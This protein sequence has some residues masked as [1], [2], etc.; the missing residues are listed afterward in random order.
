ML[1]KCHWIA[2]Y[3]VHIT[4][5]S[6]EE[7]CFFR[8]RCMLHFLDVYRYRTF[9]LIR[10]NGIKV[11]RTAGTKSTTDYATSAASAQCHLKPLL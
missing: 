1:C 8:T 5:F 11:F 10:P 2:L 6:L 4:A 3:T 7:E 9:Q